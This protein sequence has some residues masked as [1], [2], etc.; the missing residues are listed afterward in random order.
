MFVILVIFVAI[1]IIFSGRKSSPHKKRTY[2]SNNVRASKNVANQPTKQYYPSPRI[3]NSEKNTGI[4]KQISK[5][6]IEHKRSSEVNIQSKSMI[7]DSV[8]DVTGQ[9][10]EIVYGGDVSSSP[11]DSKQVHSPYSNE[12]QTFD[13]WKLGEKYKTKLQLNERETRWLNRIYDLNSQF[14]QNES[15]KMAVMRF[16]IVVLNV[17][18]KN[19]ESQGT[20]LEKT[21]EIL[22]DEIIKKEF[23]YRKGSTN[24]KYA[25]DQ[26]SSEIHVTIIKRIENAV[27]DFYGNK[28]KLHS[29][30]NRLKF[31]E[32]FQSS[33]GNKIDETID[34]NYEL[35]PPIDEQTEAE[36]N[37]KIPNRWKQRLESLCNLYIANGSEKYIRSVEQLAQANTKQIAESIYIDAAKFVAQYDKIEALKFYIKY[38]NVGWSIDK[39]ELPKSIAKTIFT[40]KI[41]IIEFERIQADFLLNKNLELTEKKL[42]RFFSTHRRKINLNEKEIEQTLHNHAE[43]VELLNG[44]L[45]EGEQKEI[46]VNK[47]KIILDE[48]AI[49]RTL[50][51]H[52]ETVELLN[53]FL[54]ESEQN[55]IAIEDSNQYNSIEDESQ[56][57]PK[58]SV[59]LNFSPVQLKALEL[60]KSNTYRLNFN[61]LELFAKANTI[62][63]NQL[64]NSINE[65]CFEILDDNLIEEEDNTYTIDEKYYKT[66]FQL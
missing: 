44:Y 53:A 29:E 16:Y 25:F 43:T 19:L 28:R 61:E 26:V 32:I 55:E 51:N 6:V 12:T 30:F 2:T 8:I 59:D 35:I 54:Q 21:I 45:Q 65:K 60:F 33:I 39:R 15:C 11:S 41:H 38:L 5:P 9:S 47:K 13:S 17:V 3:A 20:S 14:T 1:V 49:K 63:K 64:I 36:L 34:A 57:P 22:S 10:V 23:H 31:S 42:E 4:E 24:Y 56:N 66:I 27:R 62:F 50:Q 7:D 46:T 18:S 37:A 58:L 52:E 40:D 48:K